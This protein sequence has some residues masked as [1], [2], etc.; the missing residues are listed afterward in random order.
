[1]VYID[2]VVIED[3]FI[4]F[5]V[6]IST[7]IVLNR[8]IKFRNLFLAST[9]GTMPLVFIFLNL[10]ITIIHII[11][12]IFAIIM[13]IVA[14]NYKDIIYTLKNT[15]YMYF[16]SILL[17]GTIYLLTISLDIKLINP[18]I[19]CIVLVIT[20][21]I[22]SYTYIKCMKNIKNNNSNY[23]KIDIYL[24]DKPK[25]TLTAYLD[26]GNKLTNPYNNNPIILVSKKYLDI[27]NE[28]I[29]LV[30]YN[31]IDSSSLL[32][33]IKPDKIFIK[34][35]GY[36]KKIMIGLIDKEPIDGVECLLGLKALERTEIL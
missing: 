22:V 3:L 1:M 30:P 21:I 6:I 26:T 2:L 9:I 8:I 34:G 16:V 17:S 31:T 33:C 24:K 25:I 5:I 11:N 18:L 4:N 19:N 14:F 36:K 23:Y 35:I 7:G 20:A 13:S 10:E 12:F 27:A 32:T 28:K 15:I 29:L